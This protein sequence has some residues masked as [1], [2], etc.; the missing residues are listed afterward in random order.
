[1]PAP[2]RKNGLIAVFS[3]GMIAFSLLLGSVF[4]VPESVSRLPLLAALVL[5]GLPLLADLM[6]RLAGREFGADV[7]AGLSIVTSVLL[8][9]YLAGAIVVFMLSGGAALEAYALANASSVLN[10]LARRMPTAAHRRRGPSLEEIRIEDIAPGDVLV[11]LPHEICPA[12]GEVTE[13]HGRMDEAY[14]TGEPFL[15]DK[16]PGSRVLS[17]AVNGET[18]LTVRAQKPAADSRYARIVEVLRRAERDRPKIRRLGD[19]LAAFYTPLALLI[20]AAAWTASGNAVRFLSVLV[21]AT[22]CPLLI[23]IPVAILG[24]ISLCARRG[25]LVRDPSVLEEIRNCKTAV[26]D[27]TGTLTYG[28]PHLAET[29][30]APGFPQDEVLGLAASLEQYSKH[31]LARAVRSGAAERGLAPREVS[32]IR[33]VPGEGLRGR[34]SGREIFITNRATA[35]R[36]GGGLPGSSEGLECAVLVDGVWAAVLRF[37]DTPRAEGRSFIR[38][39]GPRHHFSRTLIVSGDRESEVRYLAEQVGI[40]EIF[41]GKTP[42]EKVTIVREET[43]AAKTLFVGDGMNDAPA[44]LAATVGVAIGRNSDVTSHAA[45]AVVMDASLAKVDEL[46]HIGRRMR[47]I[48]LQSAV[49]GM[50]LSLLAMLAA[51]AGFLTPVAGAVLQEGIDLLA[52]LN[53]LRAA[54]PPKELSDFADAEE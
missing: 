20:A 19:R 30:C 48:A 47:A 10:A 51:S 31:P 37:R 53:A 29:L 39:L 38:H 2:A 13:G 35:E 50:A 52:I 40:D 11:V 54:L 16:A 43:R 1:M 46:L 44:L 49:G 15:I 21:V 28:E 25:I 3:L 4:R 33:E 42:E 5:G 9:E 12:D 8:G 32:E 22:P 7:L 23:G 26:F 45:G 41:A 24:T 18:P 34:V 17:G 36:A 27:K 14:L 6:R